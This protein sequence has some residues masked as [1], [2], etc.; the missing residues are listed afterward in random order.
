VTAGWYASVAANGF[1]DFSVQPPT[2]EFGAELEA[3]EMTGYGRTYA[4]PGGTQGSLDEFVRGLED[5]G[6]I[7]VVKAIDARHG[8]G[9]HISNEHVA[10]V[11]RSSRGRLVGFAGVD[12]LDGPDAVRGLEEAVANH[13]LRGLNLQLYHHGLRAD[14]RRLWPLYDA[15]VRLAIP[16][17][18]HVGMS[19]STRPMEY[20]DPLAVDRAACEFPDLTVI[21]A[22]P[23]FPWIRE[24]I[25][26]AWRHANVH[27]GLSG[28]RPKYLAREGSGWTELLTYGKSV[29][30]EKMVFGTAYPLIPIE[31]SVGEIRA[32][33]LDPAVERAWLRDNALRVLGLDS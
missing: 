2:P 27:I 5:A 15:C 1:V 31:R 19:F 32:L 30:R 13:A 22:P 7:A 20:G 11:C 4:L 26:V 3:E 25:A 16:V 17:N 14:D 23:G 12:P 6:A 24:L 9:T 8:D 29:L 28:L 21:C 18:L 10:E 33:G